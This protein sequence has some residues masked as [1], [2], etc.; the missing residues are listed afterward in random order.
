MTQVSTS[1]QHTQAEHRPPVSHV[2]VRI[3]VTALAFSLAAAA[4]VATTQLRDSATVGLWTTVF[5]AVVIQAVPFVMLGTLVSALLATFISPTLLVRLSRLGPVGASACGAAAGIALPGCEC[6]SIP[7]AAR[8]IKQGAPTPLALAFVC[9]APGINPVVLVATSVAFPGQPRMVLARFLGGLRTAFLIG[10]LCSRRIGAALLAGRAAPDPG[11]RRSPTRRSEAASL[12]RFTSTMYGDFVHAGGF[13]VLGAALTATLKTVV[14][15]RVFTPVAGSWLAAALTM[16]L[17]AVVLS[18][19]SEA[20]AFVASGLTQFSLAARLVFL[21]V[22]PVVDLKLAA[23]HAG[24][25]GRAFAVRFIPLALL[26][27]IASALIVG[28]IL[29]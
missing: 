27:A 10:A 22:G 18:V 1:P 11:P 16:A 17:L 26:T 23:M 4:L 3:T 5:V 29:L 13:L 21:V 2:S 14:P 9:S 12:R 25:F 24:T 8:L 7:V 19:C 28:A 20:D 6:G 15:R